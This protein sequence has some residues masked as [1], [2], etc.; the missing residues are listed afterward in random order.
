MSTVGI[1]GRSAVVVIDTQVAI[2]RN[3]THAARTIETMA[4]LV[5]RARGANVPV[6]WVQDEDGLVR[7][8]DDWQL[9]PPLAAADSEHRIYKRHW[10]AFVDTD[11]AGYLEGEGVSHLLIAGAH[12]DYC[13]RTTGLRAASE[14]FDVTIVGDAHMTGDSVI[15]DE[16]L[17]ASAIVAHTNL[18]FAGLRYPGQVIGTTPLDALVL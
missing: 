6:I 7:G 2:A 8:S 5:D 10:D 12:T 16:T 18:Y 9:A 3:C 14:G 4:R 17:T 11:L 15:G 1:A 13:I